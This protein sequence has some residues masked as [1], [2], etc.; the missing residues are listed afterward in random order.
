MINKYK[1]SIEDLEVLLLSFAGLPAGQ[2][3]LQNAIRLLSLSSRIQ[4]DIDKLQK[5]Y[6]ELQAELEEFKDNWM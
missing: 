1:E 2:Q 4:D 5:E 3:A 6:G